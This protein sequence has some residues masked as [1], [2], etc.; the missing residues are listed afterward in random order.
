VVDDLDQQSHVL[1]QQ[2]RL[3]VHVPDGHEAQ[4]ITDAHATT[5]LLSAA[6]CVQQEESSQWSQ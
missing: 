5:A 2:R 1:R 6:A 4:S 3:D